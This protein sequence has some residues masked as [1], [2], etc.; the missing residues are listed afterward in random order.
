[1][2][3]VI[4]DLDIPAVLVPSSTPGHSHLLIDRVLSFDAYISLLEA[5]VTAGIVQKGYVDAAKAPHR[6]AAMLRLPW[7]R[8]DAMTVLNNP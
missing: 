1:M 8:K 4:V 7:I 6:Q 5:L 3:Q 2:H